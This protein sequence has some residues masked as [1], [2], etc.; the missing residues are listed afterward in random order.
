MHGMAYDAMSPF[1]ISWGYLALLLLPVLLAAA[2]ALVA[3]RRR[4]TTPH[5]WL[6]LL[7]ATAAGAWT[8]FTVGASV[9]VPSTQDP[10]G[11]ECVV[12]PFGDNPDRVVS[13]ESDCGKALARHMV[14][15]AGPTLAMLAVTLAAT[16]QGLRR[17]DGTVL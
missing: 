6:L 12:N 10:Q 15:S 9:M 5:L 7:A 4:D 8:F 14:I 17:R 16:A 2:V 1:G 13:W 3:V 11:S